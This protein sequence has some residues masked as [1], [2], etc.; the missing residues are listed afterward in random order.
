MPTTPSRI[1][2][3]LDIRAMPI[4]A[5]R[6]A[7]GTV[8]RGAQSCRFLAGDCAPL[9]TLVACRDA[10]GA[11]FGTHG[12][13]SDPARTGRPGRC[14]DA[15]GAEPNWLCE[16]VWDSTSNETLAKMSDWF[17]GTPVTVLCILLGAWILSH[18]AREH[19]GR[20]IQRGRRPTR[21]GRHPPARPGRAR[22]SR[23]RARPSTRRARPIDRRRGR[24]HGG[25]HHLGDRA[26]HGA[27]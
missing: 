9:R 12:A 15:C 4:R 24:R 22:Q 3:L 16:W 19:L 20:L 6:S 7:P 26:D 17:V 8:R 21:F 2:S 10:I 18:F 13:P 25:R 23:R 1:G 11:T 14:S 27:R 5:A